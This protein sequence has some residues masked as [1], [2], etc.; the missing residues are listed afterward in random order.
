EVFWPLDLLP[1]DCTNARILTWGYDSKVSHFLG[2][3]T[4]QS[5]IIDHAKNLLRAL[6][7][8]RL[9]CQGRSLIFIAH[10][11]G[12]EHESL[13]I[14]QVFHRAYEERKEPELLD[15]FTSTAAIFFLGT[16][17]KGSSTAELGET[18]RRIVSVSGI[19][20]TDQNIRALQINGGELRRIH[21][22]F[23]KLYLDDQ[24][25]FEVVETFSSSL[26]DTEPTQTINANHMSM[27]R[28]KGKDDEGYNQILGE[29]QILMSKIWKKRQHQALVTA[30][31][32]G[33][34][35]MDSP[36]QATTVSA[37]HCM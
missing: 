13:T 19:D 35:K 15:I 24:R 20:T 36:S 7:I 8:R 18:I 17:H 9:N 33:K 34:F 10:S 2:G 3:P 6:R 22:Q 26:T 11:L 12:G 5:N 4:N 14:L 29:I 1:A 25:H 28:F 31:E 16:P 30:T 21:E 27:C 32:I 37:A 23:M